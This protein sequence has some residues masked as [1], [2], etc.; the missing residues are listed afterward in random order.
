MNPELS[1]PIIYSP[2]Y[3]CA[4]IIA[5]S[6]A[7]ADATIIVFVNGN[8]VTQHKTWM[9]WGTINL[10]NPL[11]IGDEVS[12]VQQVDNRIS[13]QTRDPVTVENF[14]SKILQEEK[15]ETVEIVPP[16]IECQQIVR[17]RKVLN[18]ARV[19]IRNWDAGTYRTMTPYDNAIIGLREL[20]MEDLW[21]NAYQRVCDP[22]QFTS[23]WSKKEHVVKKPSK[24]PPVHIREP[25]IH[26]NNAIV[27]ENLIPGAIVKIYAIDK[28]GNVFAVGGGV[29]VAPET[30]FKVDPRLDV[31]FKYDATQSLCDVTSPANKT[32]V[33][34]TK[35]IPSPVVVQPI[36]DEDYYVKIC[37]TVAMGI[38]K[39]YTNGTQLAEAAGN[40]GCIKIAL[41]N[42]TKFSKG[43]KVTAKQFVEND[44]SAASPSVTVQAGG[45]LP[46]DPNYWNDP[47]HIHLN[48]CYNYACDMRTDTRAQ[49]GKAHN[50]SLSQNLLNCLG[51]D[52]GAVLDGL[53]KEQEKYC[54]NCSHL[55]ALVVDPGVD[56]HWYRLND[57][58]YWSHKP[59][60]TPATDV[61][62]S[63]NKI[64]DPEIA[65]RNYSADYSLDYSVFCGY[66]CVNK[67]IV[68]IL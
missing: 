10:P 56:Y 58:G 15:M 46:Y 55:V 16:L 19:T 40:G 21:Y 48:N 47:N 28:N 54:A 13:D 67:K 5:F 7:N 37:E 52:K 22:E 65:D 44:S 59:G 31:D 8:Q 4:E 20:K 61:D 3:K 57:D 51:V 11:N 34:P 38:V 68:E 53:K 12:A 26:G 1:P 64:T 33:T 14:P 27:L 63:N 25:I 42:K 24:L 17:V 66:Y 43:D 49:P 23:S 18:G 60:G 35:E 45:A 39:V 29:A 2:I 30:I 6:G 9:G 62:A 50:Y 32:W 41:G 36:C